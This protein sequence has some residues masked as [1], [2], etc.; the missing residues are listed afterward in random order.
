MN[1]NTIKCIRYELKA[2][3]VFSYQL[4]IIIYCNYLIVIDLAQ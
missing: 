1:Y 4:L 2:Q 3:L